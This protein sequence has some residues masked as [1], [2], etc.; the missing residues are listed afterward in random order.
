MQASDLGV[1]DLTP[2]RGPSADVGTAFELGF[3]TALGKPV[4]AY[5]NIAH[6]YIDRIAPRQLL[7]A[8]ALGHWGDEDGWSIENFSN[9]DNLML[10]GA[11]AAMAGDGSCGPPRP[12]RRAS[13]I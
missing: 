8:A 4:F 9:A 10:D 5:T 2:F 6:D 1:F 3:M 7:D 13:M 11:A 12:S